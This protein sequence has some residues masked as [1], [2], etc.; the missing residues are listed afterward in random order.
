VHKFY[1]PKRSPVNTMLA[2]GSS[3][4]IG[5]HKSLPVDVVSASIRRAVVK[6]LL[7]ELVEPAVSPTVNGGV[8][9]NIVQS[10][11]EESVQKLSEFPPE[12]LLSVAVHESTFSE[13]FVDGLDE[14]IAE[15]ESLDDPEP[16][17]SQSDGLEERDKYSSRR[18]K[19]R[20][21]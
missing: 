8:E 20:G 15:E 9:K 16:Q 19:K 7:V 5:G 17:D 6:G 10:T 4:L 11:V 14:A 2:D 18:K 12:R 1:N 3:I 21:R 13:E